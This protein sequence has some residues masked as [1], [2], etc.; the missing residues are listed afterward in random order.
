[1][2]VQ[3]YRTG[4]ALPGRPDLPGAAAHE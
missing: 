4:E 1:L 3:L 2:P